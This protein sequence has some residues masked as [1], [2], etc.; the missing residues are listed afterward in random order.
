[1]QPKKR[2]AGFLGSVLFC[3][4]I[5]TSLFFVYFEK[6]RSGSI[7]KKLKT[8]PQ[9]EC[10]YL[11]FFFRA[12][13]NVLGYCLFGNKPIAIMGYSDIFAEVDDIYGALDRIFCTFHPMNLKMSRGWE[14]WQKYQHL[15]PMKNYA[16]IKTKNLIDNNYSALILINKKEFLKIVREHLD[17]F[18]KVLGNKINPESL[19][20]E[21][22][23]SHDVFGDVLKHHDGLIGTALGFGRNNAWHYHHRWKTFSPLQKN[24]TNDEFKFFKP[25]SPKEIDQLDQ[26]L[27]SF[28]HRGILDFNPL[29]MSLPGFAADPDSI[30]T[31]RLKAEYNK[32][33]RAIIHRYQ[34]GDFLEITLKQMTS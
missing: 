10:Q 31:K 19:L 1:M 12:H 7:A 20:E 24:S 3:A 13:F 2:S 6:D 26:K 27:Q 25:I 5:I 4:T 22:L 30:E 23:T 15:F 28:D 16:F 21:V 34:K 29:L 8:I 32:Q 11:D 17:D 18:K 33:Y 14:I 9:E